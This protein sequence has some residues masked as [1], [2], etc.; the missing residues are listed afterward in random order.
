MSDPMSPINMDKIKKA[1]Y[2]IAAV[3]MATGC[4]VAISVMFAFSIYTKL[5]LLTHIPAAAY[6]HFI[7]AYRCVFFVVFPGIVAVLLLG[8]YA[9]Y[10]NSKRL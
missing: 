1:F 4:I 9:I 8:S 3:M 10:K 6:P 2:C 5:L 7:E